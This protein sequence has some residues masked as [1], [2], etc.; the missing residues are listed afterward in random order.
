MHAIHLSLR[1]PH[2][3]DG[4]QRRWCRHTRRNF[5]RWRQQQ[6]GI[7]HTT[8]AALASSVKTH[9]HTDDPVRH[10]SS[11]TTEIEVFSS[12]TMWAPLSE[13]EEGRLRG[14][15]KKK[16]SLSSFCGCC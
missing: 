3:R 6:Q 9:W 16:I 4:V 1:R 2:T 5:R 11:E 12:H 13:N 7:V 10:I 14:N 8:S 15:L